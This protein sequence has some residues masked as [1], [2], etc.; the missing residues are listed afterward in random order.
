MKNKKK[1]VLA[2]SIVAAVLLVGGIVSAIVR[3]SILDQY[4]QLPTDSDLTPFIEEQED[5]ELVAVFDDP[6]ELESWVG[7]TITQELY[8]SRLV[9]FVR[10]RAGDS[11]Q[12]N[13]L[14]KDTDTGRYGTV[15]TLTFDG[16]RKA[17][18]K[19]DLGV[20]SVISESYYVSPYEVN[21]PGWPQIKFRLPSFTQRG[22]VEKYWRN[23]F[24]PEY[25]LTQSFWFEGDRGIQLMVPMD[26]HEEIRQAL[27]AYCGG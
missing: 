27:I 11:T 22:Y 10:Q 5:W 8:D 3:N 6:A 1:L 14:Y 24:D 19:F 18:E 13:Y 20:R 16:E 23:A 26:E 17:Q 2:L 12:V 15:S 7:E 9:S 21:L 25:D 4:V